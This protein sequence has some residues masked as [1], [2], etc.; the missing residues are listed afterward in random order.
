ME[1]QRVKD[2]RLLESRTGGTVFA[3]LNKSYLIFFRIQSDV[4]ARFPLTHMSHFQFPSTIA[5]VIK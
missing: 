3:F 1:I 5:S 2:A 4:F